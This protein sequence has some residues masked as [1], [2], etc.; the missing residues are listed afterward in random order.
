MS[1][2]FIV[3]NNVINLMLLGND[4]LIDIVFFNFGIVMWVLFEND[5]K[6]K[7]EFEV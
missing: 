4:G 5:I 1:E 3:D 7:I 6:I 2:Y